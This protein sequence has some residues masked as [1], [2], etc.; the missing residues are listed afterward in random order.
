[1]LNILPLH[2][3]VPDSERYHA[4][5]KREGCL[6]SALAVKPVLDC[7]CK[8]VSS[9]ATTE[10]FFYL[11]LMT[12]GGQTEQ[13]FLVKM[14]LEPILGCVRGPAPMSTTQLQ[15]VK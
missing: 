14:R 3:D 4:N 5:V 11:R 15:I 13:H 12:Q 8:I 2:T 7:G 1:M 9:A 6:F 10:F